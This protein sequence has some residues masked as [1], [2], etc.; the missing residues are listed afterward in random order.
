MKYIL[1]DIDSEQTVGEYITVEDAIEAGKSRGNGFFCITTT[2]GSA[3]GT[4]S[5][6]QYKQQ[7]GRKGLMW[8]IILL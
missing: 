4:M 2:S 6:I 1:T 7:N 8:N 3:V 5:L